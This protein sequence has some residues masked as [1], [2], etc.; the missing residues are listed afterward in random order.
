MA[1]CCLKQDQVT[2]GNPRCRKAALVPPGSW[3]KHRNTSPVPREKPNGVGVTKVLRRKWSEW[4][5]QKWPQRKPART[6]H[7]LPVTAIK[8]I[9][10]DLFQSQSNLTVSLA[11]LNI[12]EDVW[13]YGYPHNIYIYIYIYTLY[14]R[15]IDVFV[16][17]LLD[18]AS[19]CLWDLLQHLGLRGSCVSQAIPCNVSRRGDVEVFLTSR[20][21][22]V[23][24]WYA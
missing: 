5:A 20:W 15:S 13:T 6:C 24:N 19:P 21:L 8:T 23:I 7:C 17:N 22:N 1:L 18:L 11:H 10:F 14:Y 16:L 12:S 2:H 3:P 4:V 9:S